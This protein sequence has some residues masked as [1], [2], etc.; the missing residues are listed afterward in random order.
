MIEAASNVH[1]TSARISDGATCP[2]HQREV[3]NKAEVRKGKPAKWSDEPFRVKCAVCEPALRRQ[4]AS[5]GPIG[6]PPLTHD[7]RR[8]VERSKDNVLNTSAARLAEALGL[9]TSKLSTPT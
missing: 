6:D 3:L 9:A 8:A 5:W 2:G 4:K 7:E 1:A